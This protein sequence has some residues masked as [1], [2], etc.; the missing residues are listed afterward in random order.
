MSALNKCCHNETYNE[1]HGKNPMGSLHRPLRF[2]WRQSAS[3]FP[4]ASTQ[5]RRRARVTFGRIAG[6]NISRIVRTNSLEIAG[7]NASQVIA[8]GRSSRPSLDLFLTKM[9]SQAV[10]GLNTLYVYPRNLMSRKRI[11]DFNIIVSQIN[12]GAYESYVNSGPNW[13]QKENRIQKLSGATIKG[14]LKNTAK[15]KKQSEESEPNS[16][17]G[18]KCCKS[19]HG[20]TLT[21]AREV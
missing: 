1:A 6:S 18:S 10:L 16:S 15:Y 7:V 11:D 19:F 8:R 9:E 12:A 20:V 14:A 5:Q 13:I 3:Q 2:C 17:F 21:V 4:L